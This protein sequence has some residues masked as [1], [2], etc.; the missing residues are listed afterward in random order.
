[1]SFFTRGCLHK[2][3]LGKGACSKL[4]VI[5]KR[6][7]SKPARSAV[8]MKARR[9]TSVSRDEVTTLVYPAAK[10]VLAL[11]RIRTIGKFQNNKV[12]EAAR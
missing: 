12:I 3:S 4:V 1:M 8:C 10:A 7:S 11:G 9:E 5:L 6:L 2:A